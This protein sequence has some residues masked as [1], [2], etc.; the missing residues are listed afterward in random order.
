MDTLK[1]NLFMKCPIQ[2]QIIINRLE[3]QRDYEVSKPKENQILFTWV[4]SQKLAS[5][6]VHLCG[7]DAVVYTDLMIVA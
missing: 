6:K 1:S 2:L 7:N 5:F 3:R 4:Q